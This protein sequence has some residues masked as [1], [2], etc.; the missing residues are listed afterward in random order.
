MDTDL[1]LRTLLTDLVNTLNAEN[2]HEQLDGYL[3]HLTTFN[4][5]LAAAGLPTFV[6][7]GE[8]EG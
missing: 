6:R 7:V 8:E 3:D 4:D 1:T 2:S 5:T